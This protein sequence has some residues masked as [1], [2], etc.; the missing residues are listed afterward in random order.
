MIFVWVDKVAAVLW[1]EEKHTFCL[2]RTLLKVWF[3]SG[4]KRSS[5]HSSPLVSVVTLLW[6]IMVTI[7]HKGQTA[8]ETTIVWGVRAI[9]VIGIWSKIRYKIQAWPNHS[10]TD[11]QELGWEELS[12]PFETYPY[13]FSSSNII[14]ICLMGC[15][16]V[17]IN[18]LLR[19]F[20]VTYQYRDERKNIVRNWC[21]IYTHIP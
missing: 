1:P 11:W 7:C 10:F 4:V 15:I 16:L 18:S 19:L 21:C 3:A 12:A 6:E 9:T 17:H 13:S 5:L 2:S 14:S 8:A 20:Y